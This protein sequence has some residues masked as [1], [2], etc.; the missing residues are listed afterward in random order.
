MKGSRMLGCCMSR[1]SAALALTL[2]AGTSLADLPPALDRAPKGSAV[3]IAVR[4]LGKARTNVERVVKTF[5]EEAAEGLAMLDMITEADGFN[6]NGSAAIV[7]LGDPAKEDFGDQ[8]VVLI[9]PIADWGKF[10]EGMGGEKGKKESSLPNLDGGV[11]AR[12]LGGGYAA[13]GE[14]TT[15]AGF[16]DASG[17]IEGHKALLGATGVGVADTADVIAIVNVQMFKPMID[18][19]IEE[20][21][22]Q[23]DMMAGMMGAANP[24]MEGQLNA[25]MKG[26]EDAAR[27]AQ[28]LTIGMSN[29]SG[30]A[31]AMDFAIHFKDGTANG[32][33][34][35]HSGGLANNVLGAMP[36]M[37][38][39]GAIAIDTAHP[40]IRGVMIDMAKAQAKQPNPFA[41]M[42]AMNPAALEKV[43]A[44][45]F[46][47]GSNPALLS[48]GMFAKALTF[49]QGKDPAGLL[50]EQRKTM[51]GIKGEQDGVKI[52]ATF[53]PDAVEI[54]GQKVDRLKATI[55]ID[56]DSPMAQAQ[57]FLTLFT[58]TSGEMNVMSTKTKTGVLSTMSANTDLMTK[59]I[60]AQGGKG[61]LAA[62]DDFKA[63]AAAL[64]ENR[65][66]EGYLGVKGMADTI[67]GVLQLFG[68]P[69]PVEIKDELPPIGLG[70]TATTGGLRARLVVPEKVMNT[71]ADIAKKEGEPA[72]VAP[73]P[74]PGER[75][76]P[77]L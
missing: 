77:R 71:F 21:K 61:A 66:F 4:D 54:A 9:L 39:L 57:Q 18:Q 24:D 11:F 73:D 42:N 30:N 25:L 17:Q 26:L 1:C 37:P 62:N 14:E 8:N 51:G 48:T 22:N 50:E 2:L 49:Q 56:P 6:K 20:G 19:G 16:K 29:L 13:L 63:V 46:F 27:D 59:A 67:A 31:L 12:D 10:V 60:E 75:R 74:Q 52:D 64:P 58:G 65:A 3:T 28:S 41:G 72:K 44:I 15:L 53:T 36:A 76:K 32:K 33:R 34:F 45:G 38:F 40:F 43:D 23:M 69:M 68:Q 7:M 35:T 70:A 47:M 55:E 5:N